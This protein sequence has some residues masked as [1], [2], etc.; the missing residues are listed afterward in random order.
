MKFL[1]FV[2]LHL[3]LVW[4]QIPWVYKLSKAQEQAAA[5]QKPIML[6]Y[7]SEECGMCT[8]MKRQV[9]SQAH[10]EAY[11]VEHFVPLYIDVDLDEALK[12]FDLFGTP[13]FYFMDAQLKK[14][15]RIVGGAKVEPFLEELKKINHRFEAMH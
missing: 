1:L 9:F 2:M 11:I 12:G 3:S 13:T 14:V 6:M 7:A 15:G 4:A 8:F 5:T 10:A